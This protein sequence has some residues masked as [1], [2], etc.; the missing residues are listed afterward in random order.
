MWFN[1]IRENKIT[2]KI[3]RIYSKLITGGFKCQDLKA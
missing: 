3:F 2:A 1:A